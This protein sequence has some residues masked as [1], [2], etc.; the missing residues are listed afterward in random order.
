MDVDELKQDKIRWI[1]SSRKQH[2]FEQARS[3]F[4]RISKE[5][6]HKIVQRLRSYEQEQ[7]HLTSLIEIITDTQESDSEPSVHSFHS[8]LKGLQDSEDLEPALSDWLQFVSVHGVEKEHYSKMMEV[9]QNTPLS[10]SQQTE[11]FPSCFH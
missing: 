4:A 2:L 9:L 10:M 11:S 1:L 7:I 6:K 8:L 3:L 5:D